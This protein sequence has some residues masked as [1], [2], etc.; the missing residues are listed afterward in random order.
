MT[1]RRNA[2]ERE[3]ANLGF[4]SRALAN[5]TRAKSEIELTQFLLLDPGHEA[6][7]LFGLGLWM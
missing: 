7:E 3:F 1:N 4:Q 5:E 2:P 6:T